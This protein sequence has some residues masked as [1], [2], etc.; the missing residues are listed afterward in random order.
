MKASISGKMFEICAVL[1]MIHKKFGRA[2]GLYVTQNNMKKK[3]E[4]Y[5]I[6]N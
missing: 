1:G 6:D 2:K 3:V 4:I 5:V